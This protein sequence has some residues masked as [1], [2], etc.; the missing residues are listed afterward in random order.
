MACKFL[1]FNSFKTLGQISYF[2]K[3]V[4]SGFTRFKNRLAFFLLSI[5]RYT[6][7]SAMGVFFLI[8]YPEGEKKVRTILCLE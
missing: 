3:M 1:V 8:S 5:G 7:T 6:T 2:T 4:N